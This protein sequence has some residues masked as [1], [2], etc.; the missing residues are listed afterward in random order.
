M[1]RLASAAPGEASPGWS[2][3]ESKVTRRDSQRTP[4]VWAGA[5][6]RADGA[7]GG[8]AAPPRTPRLRGRR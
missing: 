6:R 1:N 2:A 8:G 3:T 5:A 4:T 7:T